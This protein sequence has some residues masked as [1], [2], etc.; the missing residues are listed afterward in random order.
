MLMNCLRCVPFGHFLSGLA[1]FVVLLTTACDRQEII[2]PISSVPG[3]V[4]TFTGTWSATGDR[5]TMKLEPGHKAE[6]FRLSGSLL[7][8]GEQRLRK[9]FKA[10]S[11]GFSDNLSGGLQGRSVWTDDRG[12]KVFSEFHGSGEVP[13]KLIE[14]RFLGGT[15]R[16]ARVSGEYTFRWKHLINNENG[17]V[18]GR[19]VD[20]KGWFRDGAPETPPTTT[21][22]Q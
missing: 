17:K 18:S 12:D 2:P 5:Q 19:V 6:I 13:G 7:L 20:L 22:G 10:V 16:Y 3:E 8:A 1:L 4:Q 14:G 21:G 9:G 11:I 15:G